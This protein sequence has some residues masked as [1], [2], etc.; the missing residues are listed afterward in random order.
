MSLVE[1]SKLTKTYGSGP[2]AV[3]ALRDINTSV[4]PGEFVAIMLRDGQIID[5]NRMN[6]RANADDIRERLGRMAVA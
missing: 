5:E 6:G 4:E 1:T 3:Y 2:Q